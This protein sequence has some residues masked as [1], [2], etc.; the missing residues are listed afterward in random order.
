MEATLDNISQKKELGQFFSGKLVAKLLLALSKSDEVTTVIDPMC[1]I[2]DMLLQFDTNA[3]PLL[4]LS[5]IEIDHSVFSNLKE[6]IGES[7]SFNLIEG[8]AF[9]VNVIRQICP[10]GYD[11]VITNPPYV[12]HQTIKKI[13]ELFPSALNMKGIRTNMIEGLSHFNT[14]T[15]EERQLAKSTISNF[16]G[17]SDL[18][19]PSWILCSLMVKVGGRLA[20]V[21]PETWLNRDYAQ[22]VKY[23]LLRWFQI[24]YI[25]EDANS[26][27][28]PSAQVKTILL[29]AKRI[30]Q[31]KSILSW[32]NERF[33]YIQLYSKAQSEDSL[34]G[35]IYIS[36]PFPE[37]EFISS[38]K[39]GES[40]SDFFQNNSVS[41][42][43]FA[44]ELHSIVK[45]KN[46]TELFT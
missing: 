22:I 2:G 33:N 40:V 45:E 20:I 12:R 14:L 16:S 24:E 11:L 42:L 3:N 10:E 21:V 19:V 8:N 25:I 13:E 43:E 1:G 23:L 35:N 17:L 31:K 46:G 34:V 26:K 6:R 29:V 27:W 5:G 9:A 41:I 38:I 30:R 18:A 39:K 32:T 37:K 7:S 36:S 4:R 28:F 44:Q 15:D